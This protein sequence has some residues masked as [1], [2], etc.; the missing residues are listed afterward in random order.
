M[1]DANVGPQNDLDVATRMNITA[2]EAIRSLNGVQRERSQGLSLR[3]LIDHALADETDVEQEIESNPNS[4]TL[5]LTYL[6]VFH[7]AKSLL[8]RLPP[9]T[10]AEIAQCHIT[11]IR[12]SAEDLDKI[13][14]LEAPRKKIPKILV[15]S[16]VFS[17]WR[18]VILNTPACW[19][20]IELL[21]PQTVINEFVARSKGKF[22]SVHA[23]LYQGDIKMPRNFDLTPLIAFYSD[24][25]TRNMYRVEELEIWI[26]LRG[27]HVSGFWE[28]L[29]RLHAPVLK[30]FAFADLRPN[31]NTEFLLENLFSSDTPRLSDVTL[32]AVSLS[33]IK[34]EAFQSLVSLELHLR[35]H[36]PIT[37]LT[38]MLS[39]TPLLENLLV[40]GSDI[41]S[42]PPPTLLQNP[43][44]RL[45]HC[46][47]VELQRMQAGTINYIFSAT[48]VNSSPCSLTCIQR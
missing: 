9:E 42:G 29:K 7:N 26:D 18:N 47:I 11:D 17:L 13:C 27:T 23:S 38:R 14:W 8:A 10:L 40:F 39:N 36:T 24:F 37:N 44:T 15:I 12:E 48:T 43:I 1:S 33:L 16:H 31:A 3:T 46:R 34:P 21:W 32:L 25:L 5:D 28:D 45:S 6:K 41:E 22:L 19:S 4:D 20:H 30:N 35:P 2:S